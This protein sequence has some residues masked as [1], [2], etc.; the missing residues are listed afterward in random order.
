MGEKQAWQV[1]AILNETPE[2]TLKFAA[3]YL[4]QGAQR[5]TLLCDNPEDPVLSLLADHPQVA[6]IPCT[7]DFWRGLGME[8]ETR[9]PKRQNAAMTWLYQQ[10]SR[11]WFLNVDA[12][13]FLYCSQGQIEAL[14]AHQPTD[15]TSV[16]VA[17]AEA[18]AGEGGDSRQAFRLPM[19]RDTS[20][21]V[22]QED[23]FLFP[24]RRMGLVGHPQGKSFTRCGD[25]TLRLRQHWPER[26]RVGRLP[27]V[28]LGA[29]SGCYL[30][31]AIG[32]D[33][34]IW[35]AKLLWRIGSS[36]F[37]PGLAQHIEQILAG[38]DPEPA[39]RD[40]HQKLHYASAELAQRMRAAGVLLELALG[41]DALVV[42]HFG[43]DG[44]VNNR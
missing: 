9:F 3:W 41:L 20:R 30:L 38:E 28:F 37:R 34:D 12:D 36:G 5:V 24:P 39:L 14:L 23:A 11:G 7:E 22:Y 27:E 18:L 44:A 13:E 10:Q 19:G 25:A 4:E 16:R 1:G 29:E 32:A 42:K 33:Y 43:D 17:T 21:D 40:L 6:C 31:H 35:R 26:R 8:N 15:T 2:V